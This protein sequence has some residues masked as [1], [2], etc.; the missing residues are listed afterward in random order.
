MNI[1]TKDIEINENFFSPQ[2][3]LSLFWT[4]INQSLEA[5]VITDASSSPKI[6]YV[7]QTFC[8]MTGYAIHELIG[9]SP[10]IL[11]GAQTDQNVIQ[12]MKNSINDGRYFQGFTAN[13]KKDRTL[14]Y[15]EW[16]IS[17]IKDDGENVTHYISSQ[18]DITEKI[19]I[20]HERDLLAQA[21]N[22][23]K[24]SVLIIDVNN[25]I[26]F[27]NHGFEM[28]TDY[29]SSEVL[30]RAVSFL[31]SDTDTD[32]IKLTIS[33]TIEKGENFG[34]VFLHKRKNGDSFFMK[35]SLNAIKNINNEVTHCVFFGSDSTEQV[36][37]ERALNDLVSKD[38]LTGLLN[39][40][41]GEQ[42]LKVYENNHD[43]CICMLMIDIDN[44]K[45]INDNFGHNIGD[46]VLIEV[47]NIL[48]HNARLSDSVFRWG[49]EEFL[50]LIPNCELGI[51]TELA[52]R[53]R[54]KIMSIANTAVNQ[55][56]ISIGVAK[57]SKDENIISIIDRADKALYQAKKNG[58]NC[59]VV[60]EKL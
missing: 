52:E 53:F 29:K 9:R 40:R 44:F 8:T 5:V 22:D 56:T 21:L 1:I 20:Q 58:K 49:G 31:F 34:G 50:I 48:K 54:Q 27:V 39:R 43:S 3:G 37:R 51:A 60:A 33:K 36:L 14:Y 19:Q 26:V 11:Q 42:M 38:S 41:A 28:L 24:E 7:N 32:D 55:I 16:N 45:S 6:V 25:K 4:A 46:Q 10:K 12:E 15:V 57:L 30:G 23:A 17:P 18:R 35:M 47:S 59:I 2:N 13:Y